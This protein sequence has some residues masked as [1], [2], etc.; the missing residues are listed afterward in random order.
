MRVGGDVEVLRVSTQQQV[1]HA[2][3]HEK[4]LVAGIL[5]AVQDFQCVLGDV[6]PGNIVIGPGDDLRRETCGLWNFSQKLPRLWDC[7]RNL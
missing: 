2:A 1:A 3:A 7:L 5:Q 6:G 4:G